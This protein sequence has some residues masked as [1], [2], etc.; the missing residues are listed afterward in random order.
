V[1]DW[2]GPVTNNVS[3]SHIIDEIK[4]TA[5]KNGG[6]PLGKRRFEHDTGIRESDWYGRHWVKWSDALTDAGLEPNSM[7]APYSKDYLLEQLA[8]LVRELGHFPVHGELR[9]KANKDHQF[10]SHNTFLRLGHKDEMV[11]KLVRWCE[12]HGG[13]EDVIQICAPLLTVPAER[14]DQEINREP[15]VEFGQVYLLKSGRF[16]KIGRTN[17]VGRRER[18][19]AIQ[20]PTKADMIHVI[21]TD[22]PVGIES[23]W[24]NRFAE[25]RRNGE[26]FELT[27][28]DISVFKRR[29][30][31]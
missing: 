4:R 31:M 26:W 2:R 16:Y 18:E 10:P 17:A 21:K 8:M 6:S 27:L 7:N 29:K 23:Y 11:Q 20:L 24:H 25:K 19:L 28:A 14:T 1:W 15:S 9:M 22:D 5:A 30:F 3:K 12:E 13:H